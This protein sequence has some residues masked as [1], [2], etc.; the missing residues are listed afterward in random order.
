MIT[1]S[2]LYTKKEK[3]YPVYIS[4][5]NSNREKQVILL[6]IQTRKDDII[7]Q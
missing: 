4:K 6:I 3:I 5:N 7:L 2:L 1:V